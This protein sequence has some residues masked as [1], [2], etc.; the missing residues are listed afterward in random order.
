MSDQNL[1]DRLEG[2]FSSEDSSPSLQDL[3][4]AS[5][6]PSP[7]GERQDAQAAALQEQ[8]QGDTAP[9]RDQG[10]PAGQQRAPRTGRESADRA[11]RAGLSLGRLFKGSRLAIS[12]EATEVRLLSVRGQS[13]LRWTTSTLAAGT[14]RNGQLVQPALFGQVV[15]EL[16]Q[17]VGGSRR[18]AVVSLSGQRSL[19]RILSLPSV[20][21]QMLREAVQREARRELPLP[22]EELYLSWQVIGSRGASGCDVLVLGIPRDAVDSFIAG[23]RSAGVRTAA[24]DLKPLA[25][26]RAANLPDVLLADLEQ[27]VGSVI[28]VRGYVPYI[29][30]SIG[31]PGDTDRPLADRADHLVAEIRRTLDFYSA[32]MAPQHPP[33]T[34]VVCLTGALAGEPEVRSRVGPLWPL[35]EPVPPIPLPQGLPLPPYLVN[36]GLALKQVSK[37]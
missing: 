22:L 9:F 28:L 5:D 4:S 3:F 12:L 31:L 7:R 18:G 10:Q 34:P 25:L 23:L 15:R 32:T 8:P 17:Q 37:R 16:V 29:S 26:V 21:P 6:V 35:V 2:L 1:K 33:W 27:T 19:V 24:M 14:V 36:V 20:P 30:R 11:G 13:I